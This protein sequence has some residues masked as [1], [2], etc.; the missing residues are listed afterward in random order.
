[1]TQD[2]DNTSLHYPCFVEAFTQAGCE[3]G[4]PEPYVRWSGIFLI[5]TVLGRH[6]WLKNVKSITYPNLYVMLVGPAG[7]GKSQAVDLLTPF[8][9]DIGIRK[10][11][12]QMTKASMIDELY[13]SVVFKTGPKGEMYEYHQATIVSSELAETFDGADIP[14]LA[15]LNN[16]WDCPEEFLERKRHL[17][18]PKY[19]KFIC[20]NI[21]TGIQ[22]GTLATHFP[23]E[24]WTSGFF[25]RT[26]FIYEPR[27]VKLL[28]RTRDIAS[29]VSNNKTV[30][31]K[32]YSTLITDL[33][34]ISTMFGLM[35]EDASFIEEYLQWAE[36]DNQMPKPTHPRL[37]GYNI[38]RAHQLEK[39][40]VIAAAS[41]GSM[42]LEGKD[43]IKARSWL[44]T[45]EKGIDDI[46]LE[47]S[48]TDDLILMKDL[49]KFLWM[50]FE[51]AG[52]KPVPIHTV[53]QFLVF[54]VGE[55]RLVPFLENTQLAGF[56][57][58]MYNEYGKA[59]FVKPLIDKNVELLG[60]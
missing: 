35:K 33:S 22:P 34:N 51:S 26:L 27:P 44:E 15:T 59:I 54:K 3:L 58:I 7:T 50:E 24:I 8:L 30:A 1:M 40:S 6:V 38:R 32:Y 2:K 21:L 46:F 49:H 41:R 48:S 52:Q 36:V 56:I 55:Q 37:E 9:Q 5:A 47:M 53:A 20:C 13:D 39:L 29:E 43:Y 42:L 25:A 60:G 16:W 12:Q 11:A 4:I 28:L 23:P 57:K 10:T 45:V 14:H 19:I 18:E 31:P 17:G